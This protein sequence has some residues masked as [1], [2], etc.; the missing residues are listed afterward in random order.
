MPER[1][2]IT[3]PK[4]RWL[5]V[6]A[7]I[8]AF[9]V[10]V[11]YAKNGIFP[12][13]TESVVHDD[14]GQ[15]NIPILYTVWDA[16]HGNGSILLNLRTAGGVFISGAYECACSPIN[17][18]FFLICPRDR[19]LDSMS[20]FLLLKI[21]LAAST[22]MILFTRKFSVSPFWCAL[23]AVCYAFN[24]FL[25][26][27][28]SNASWLEIVWA[29]PL[30]LLGADRLLHGKNV[31]LYTLTLAYCLI[32]QLYISYMVVLFLFFEGAA[33]TYLLLPK[34][35]RKAAAIRFGACTMLAVL[36]SAF[37]TL[38]SFFYMTASS[39]FQSTKSYTQVLMNI[40]KNASQKF[41]MIA[42]LTA[43]GFALVL[44]ALLHL[45]RHK[46]QTLFMV[47]SLG[48]LMIPVLFENVNLLW[49]MGSYVFFPMRFAFLLHLTILLAACYS[50]EQ[51][52]DTLFRGGPVVKAVGA[53]AFAVLAVGAVLGW[54]QIQSSG[55]TS[56]ITKDLLTV[57]AWSFAALCL[58]YF[59]LLQFGI[60]RAA[61]LLIGMLIAAESTFFFERSV[62]SGSRRTFE[63]SLD[64]I[65]ESNDIYHD[66]AL[67]RSEFARIKNIDGSLNTNYPLI[68]DYPSMSNFTH[69]IPSTI[70]LSMQRL[71]YSTVYT[72]ILDTGGTLF[73]DRLLGCRYALSLDKLPENSYHFV[74]HAGSYRIYES[75]FAGAFG[76]VCSAQINDPDLFETTAFCTNNRLWHIVQPDAGDLFEIVKYQ[77]EKNTYSATYDFDVNG[78][79][80]LYLVCKGTTK[81]KNM[82][83]LVNGRI[84]PIPSLGEP[85]NTCYTTRFNNSLLDLGEYADTHVTVRVLLL[86]DTISNDRLVTKIALLDKEKLRQFVEDSAQNNVHV[87]AEGQRIEAG[88]FSADDGNVLFLPIAYDSG[89]SCT[90]NGKKVQ[91]AQALGTFM[92]VPL[93][94][95]ENTIRMHYYPKG[96]LPGIVIS[97]VALTLL[98][99]YLFFERRLLAFLQKKKI[100]S[101]ILVAYYAADVGAAIALYIVPI[102]CQLYTLA[103]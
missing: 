56:F 51:F 13:G 63:Y 73:T 55:G 54:Q 43:L 66:L 19:L 99:I 36:L 72:R 12:F 71:G 62:T 2:E 10:L 85:E 86:N 82:Q 69:T 98:A 67:D 49:H 30:V 87:R 22:A 14:M 89:W 24:P 27:Y 53:I 5:F 18:L 64:F 7:V 6:P 79:K 40:S 35:A 38:P 96:F 34:D 100:A 42:V 37:S 97:L 3:A 74:G 9:I 101:V 70:K 28:Y 25:L 68:I 91:P 61:Y 8:T 77:E 88:A 16:L 78:T 26:Q 84:V 46:R 93:E 76:T 75:D 60:R 45:R 102:I 57:F 15:C 47:F 52:G 48:L 39:R 95:G 23:F 29:A 90:V 103:S 44:V 65:S 32:V 92:S 4:R 17:V 81:R 59:L 83:I 33:Y 20:F 1:T 31:L 58:G 80:E 50:I 41:A 21:I 11:V 94:Q